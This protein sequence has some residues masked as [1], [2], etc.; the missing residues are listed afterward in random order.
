MTMLWMIPSQLLRGLV[1]FTGPDSSQSI[2]LVNLI[3]SGLVVVL[4]LLAL[5][6]RRMRW[7]VPMPWDIFRRVSYANLRMVCP[8][9]YAMDSVVLEVTQLEPSK[10]GNVKSEDATLP[11]QELLEWAV[12]HPYTGYKGG[13]A[14]LVG[15]ILWLD[16]ENPD[17]TSE[18]AGFNDIDLIYFLQDGEEH[19]K[20][21]MKALVDQGLTIGGIPV[22]AQD[23]EYSYDTVGNILATRDLTQNQCIVVSD[24]D[25]KVFLINAKICRE[26]MLRSMTGPATASE[27][28]TLDDRGNVIARPRVVGRALVQWMKGRARHIELSQHT[29]SFYKQQKL[30]KM[31]MFQIFA[32]AKGN[33]MYMKV[34]T[35]LVRL[36]FVEKQQYPHVL[37]GECYA[38]VNSLIARHGYRLELES[39]LNSEAVERWKE[40][41][42]AEQLS[43]TRVSAFR[44]FRFHH[45]VLDESF[46]VPYSLAD[47]ALTHSLKMHTTGADSSEH[48]SHAHLAHLRQIR[49]SAAMHVE[50]GSIISLT[51]FEQT[52]VGR[53][54]EMGGSEDEG[55]RTRTL[56]RAAFQSSK[57]RARRVVER[58]LTS[59]GAF[60]EQDD[61]L[62]DTADPLLAQSLFGKLTFTEAFLQLLRIGK[63]AWKGFLAAFLVN[64]VAAVLYILVINHLLGPFWL[65]AAAATS[66]LGAWLFIRSANDAM[67]NVL[68]AMYLALL[69]IKTEAFTTRMFSEVWSRLVGDTRALQGV[70]E[71]CNDLSI[72]SLTVLG[73]LFAI[74]GL[75]ASAPSCDSKPVWNALFV[76][77]S[78]GALMAAMSLLACFSLRSNSRLTRSMIGYMYADMFSTLSN[79]FE[80]KSMAE[81]FASA[82]ATYEE[83]QD[84]NLEQRKKLTLIHQ[85][86]QIFLRYT[87]LACI[88]LA[89]YKLFHTTTAGTSAECLHSY[90]VFAVS[91]PI[92]LSAIRRACEALLQLSSSIGSLERLFLLSRALLRMATPRF[93]GI[94]QLSGDV[95]LEIPHEFTYCLGSAQFGPFAKIPALA[96]AKTGQLNVMAMPRSSGATTFAKLLLRMHDAPAKIKLNGE[97]VEHYE[98]ETINFSVHIIDH[99]PLPCSVAR[100]PGQGS[101]IGEYVQM[102]LDDMGMPLQPCLEQA[103]IWSKVVNLPNGIESTDWASN[104]SKPEALRV[105]LAQAIF[106]ISLGAV[107]LLLII[108]PLRNC[109]ECELESARMTWTK[110]LE[111]LKSRVLV[112]IVDQTGDPRQWT[113]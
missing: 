62:P 107:R 51:G 30:P 72:E 102:G 53:T 79:F 19:K 108:D 18:I 57:T 101:S 85:L 26:H 88:M 83:I 59:G 100:T 103:G 23:V 110:A 75:A 15:K 48:P 94:N 106:R 49:S 29:T 38:H 20:D 112:L 16:S 39:E 24:G 68:T 31:T 71:A 69:N 76:A 3:L 11:L 46:L 64:C 41:K 28:S 37:W 113:L 4:L 50:G 32:K 21:E 77:F 55:S 25:G 111:P 96:A 1:G 95:V 84:A 58:I 92:L 104:M 61:E 40:A 97:H 33:E 10:F 73:T 67:L 66:L 91:V 6:W 12:A 2:A 8:E 98:L 42:Y 54:F 13:I 87:E 52:Q 34:Y 80:V 43:R 14:R 78:A 70:L 7:P 74:L 9:V 44:D 36:G 90:S 45:L 60:M 86:M 56:R 99:A 105:Q 82:K 65:L 27:V 35:E 81:K 109:N 93:D 63:L 47:T 17:L 89:V 5:P 22:E